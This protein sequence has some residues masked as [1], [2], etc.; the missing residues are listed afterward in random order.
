[1]NEEVG[2][3]RISSGRWGAEQEAHESTVVSVTPTLTA[4]HIMQTTN[5]G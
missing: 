2:M 5:T 4:A 3:R 1:V